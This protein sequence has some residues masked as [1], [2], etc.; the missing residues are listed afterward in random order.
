MDPE[1]KDLVLRSRPIVLELLEAR[2]YDTTPYQD[3]A[4]SAVYSLAMASLNQPGAPPL[5]IRVQRKEDAPQSP[6][7][8]C[9]VVYLIFEKIKP[10]IQR[11]QFEEGPGRWNYIESPENTDYIFIIGEAYHECFDSV[12]M[13]AWQKKVKISFFHIKQLIMNPTKHVLVPK[14]QRV[15]ADAVADLKKEL[16]LTSLN[17]L[18]F[19]KYH[20]DVQARWLGLTPGEVIKIIRPSV[21]AGETDVYRLCVP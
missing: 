1:I 2:G 15:A 10:T 11:R 16:N 18:P 21:T 13:Q 8:F 19:I 20:I 6:Y 12:A 5:K 17:R 7:K 4:P 14:H 3:Q 9:E